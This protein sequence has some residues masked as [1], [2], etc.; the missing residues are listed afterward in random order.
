MPDPKAHESVN[1][2]HGEVIYE[3]TRVLEWLKFW[4][5][6][7]VTIG[8][9]MSIW[10]PF[11]MAFKT[12][13]V[14]DAADEYFPITYHLVSPAAMDTI[15]AA[16]PIATGASIYLTY[17]FVNFSNIFT[18]QYIVKMS[19]SKDKVITIFM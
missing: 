18:N 4:Q 1:F 5:T 7:T 6:T 14:T 8:G 11:N 16:I 19:Y 17:V 15:H 2:E 3:N 9:F 10:V 12:N 13:L